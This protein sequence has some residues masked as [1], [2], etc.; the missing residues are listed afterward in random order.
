MGQ[1]WR[2]VV[3]AL[4]EDF[5]EFRALG[6]LAQVVVRLALAASLG[7]LLGYDRTIRRRP[8]GLRTYMLVALGAAGFVT[9]PEQLGMEL[10]DLSRVIQGLIAGVGF[11]GAG[12][13]FRAGGDRLQARGLT[14]A[15][16][17]WLTA[18]V[19]MAVGLGRPATAIFLTALALIILSPLLRLEWKIE[20]SRARA[21]EPSNP[22]QGDDEPAGAAGSS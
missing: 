11:L 12:V 13:I 8:A 16:G 6:G 4:A 9:V 20:R 10:S 14:T 7:G 3:E 22:A 1:A 18:S 19:G 5:S 15:A 21:D 17:I 2:E